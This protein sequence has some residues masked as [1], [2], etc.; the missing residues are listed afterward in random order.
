MATKSADLDAR[1]RK[2]E[3]L[4]RKVDDDITVLI[5]TV[6]D[7]RE[8]IQSLRTQTQLTAANVQYLMKDMRNLRT[9]FAAL[10]S[11]VA[12]LDE[13]FTGLET[14]FTGLETRF[15]DLNAKVDTR[16]DYLAR[17]VNL[18]LAHQ[19]LAVEE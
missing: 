1:V 6:D 8:A 11:R 15:N 4:M 12:G 10:D 7:N 19:G 3:T 16:F 5:T 17:G 13:R 2:L 18:L 14:R 9:E